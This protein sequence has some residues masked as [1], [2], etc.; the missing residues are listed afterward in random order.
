MAKD[1]TDI[2]EVF[3]EDV[4]LSFFDGFQPSKEKKNEK[5]GETMAGRYSSNFLIPKP[6]AGNEDMPGFASAA[7]NLAALKKAKDAKLKEKYGD[8][9]PKI[10]PERLCTRDGDLEDWDGYEDNFYVSSGRSIKDGPPAIVNKRRNPVAQGDSQAPY[11]GC[12]VNAIV[13][14]WV[15]DNSDGGK[16][17]NAALEAVQFLADGEPFAKNR[18]VDPMAKFKDVS[19]GEDDVDPIG[20]NGDD[21]DDII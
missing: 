7:K 14:L 3:L 4:R 15:Q 6:K 10:K 13:R 19:N 16:R 2:G 18:P 8:D 9:V 21:D 12:Q 20:G 17:V 1:D 5:T 11:A